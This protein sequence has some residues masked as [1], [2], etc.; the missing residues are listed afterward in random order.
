MTKNSSSSGYDRPSTD[1]WLSAIAS[2]SADCPFITVSML[3][4]SLRK[5][6][7]DPTLPLH[8]AGREPGDVVVEEEDVDADDR[9]RRE[10]RPGHERAPVV[11]VATDQVR[12]DADDR[13]LVGALRDEG[14]GVDELVPAQREAEERR[15]D[16]AGHGHR[17]HDP[18]ER[19]H[20]GGAVDERAL[21]DLPRHRPEVAH[22]EPRAEGH[23]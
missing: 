20:P 17:E 21:L 22:E 3:A 15:A 9:H 6:S 23:E 10:H 19:L 12:G 11:D 4:A 13:G 7:W 5:V 8:R 16:D 1:T 2:R 18:G 14:E